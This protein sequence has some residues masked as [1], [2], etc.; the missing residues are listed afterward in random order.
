M[1][2]DVVARKEFRDALRSKGLWVLSLV[3]TAFFVIPA[4]AALWFDVGIRGGQDVGMQLL[5][6]V[7]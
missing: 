3:F 6:R 2:W 7:I 5:I 1:S 4:A